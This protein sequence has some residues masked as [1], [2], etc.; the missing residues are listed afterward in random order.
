MLEL[1]FVIENEKDIK[2]VLQ[3][4]QLTPLVFKTKDSATVPPFIRLAGQK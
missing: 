3:K 4:A 2:K 1:L